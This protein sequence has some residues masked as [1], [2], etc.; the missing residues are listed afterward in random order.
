M[1]DFI[2]NREIENDD[3][4]PPDVN[5]LVTLVFGIKETKVRDIRYSTYYDHYILAF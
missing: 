3:D 1:Y 5:N 4:I 2:D